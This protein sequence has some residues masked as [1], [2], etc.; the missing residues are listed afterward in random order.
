MFKNTNTW[1]DFGA[2]EGG[3]TIKFIMRLENCG[4]QEAVKKLCEGNL[5]TCQVQKSSSEEMKKE[6]IAKIAEANA[7]YAAAKETTDELFIRRFFKEKGVRYYPE[8][9]PVT[10]H[11]NGETYIAIPCPFPDRIQSL[12]CRSLSG[13]R[14]TFGRKI[15]WILK[16]DS[17]E[18][19]ITESI[20]DGLA[21]DVYFGRPSLSLCALNG[22]PNVKW[23]DQIVDTY[24]PHKMLLALDNDLAGKEAT[25]KAKE[26]LKGKKVKVEIVKD[27]INAGVK[28]LHKLLTAESDLMK[29]EKAFTIPVP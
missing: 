16:R 8:I 13:E 5:S 22:I 2:D 7:L 11:Y 10:L 25:E 27:H 17:Q 19:L 26:I 12:E 4:F 20:L 23:L 24:S 14:K 15:P 3:D 1:F 21:G 6:R 18:F 9:R 28:D 29:E